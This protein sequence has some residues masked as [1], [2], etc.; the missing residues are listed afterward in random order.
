[1]ETQQYKYLGPNCCRF[2]NL[3]RYTLHTLQFALCFVAY[4]LNLWLNMLRLNHLLPFAISLLTQCMQLFK[5][6]AE[7]LQT[8]LHRASKSVP[9]RANAYVYIKPNRMQSFDHQR[10]SQRHLKL[11]QVFH[12]KCYRSVINP[13][14]TSNLL[15][16]F[17]GTYVGF[18]RK[19]ELHRFTVR[20]CT[21]LPLLSMV[22]MNDDD[23]REYRSKD[24]R[25]SSRQREERELRWTLDSHKNEIT[26][27]RS[28]LVHT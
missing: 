9:C 19:R 1:M 17:L 7:L 10:K 15:I 23:D 2:G 24:L 3:V 28:R 26:P 25:T 21:D 13:D 18:R 5:Q 20:F 11:L 22:S 27:A 12:R 6:P 16:I 4:Y 8:Y 14:V